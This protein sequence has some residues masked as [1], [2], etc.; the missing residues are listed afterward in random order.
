VATESSADAAHVLN[1]D[2]G[3]RFGFR[4]ADDQMP[5][6]DGIEP[7]ERIR[8]DSRLAALRLIMLTTRDHHESNSETV[9]CLPRSHQPLRRSQLM[10]CVT[11]AM[12]RRGA[13]LK[14]R[15]TRGAAGRGC[16]R[17]RAKSCW[18]RTIR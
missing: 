9:R 17:I 16:A 10:N 8:E 11:R 7:G 15:H 5:G 2:E 4:A 6:M 18:S 14:N 3:P 12:T 13:E 1:S